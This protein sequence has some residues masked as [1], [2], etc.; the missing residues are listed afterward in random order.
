MALN[1]LFIPLER[2]IIDA[3]EPEKRAAGLLTNDSMI[4][5][6]MRAY[7][8]SDL[9]TGDNLFDSVAHVTVFSPRD[10]P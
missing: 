3:A 6:A 4:V 9:A 7:G 2:E 5:A 8:I 1:L 10:L